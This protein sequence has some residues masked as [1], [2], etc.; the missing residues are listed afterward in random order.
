MKIKSVSGV[1]RV[2]P[3]ISAYDRYYNI[4]HLTFMILKGHSTQSTAQPLIEG[5]IRGIQLICPTASCGKPKRS[6]PQEAMLYGATHSHP[7]IFNFLNDIIKEVAVLLCRNSGIDVC[8][9]R[10]LFDLENTDDLVLVSEGSSKFPV[11]LIVGMTV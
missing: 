11:F 8:S 6:S 10:G 7:V 3:I 4:D 5:Y 2:V 1:I 9:D